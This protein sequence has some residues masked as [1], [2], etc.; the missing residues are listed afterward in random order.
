VARLRGQLQTGAD[1]QP[2]AGR[3]DPWAVRLAQ[4]FHQLFDGGIV[5]RSVDRLDAHVAVVTGVDL[6]IDRH[7]DRKDERIGRCDVDRGIADRHQVF[8]LE[9]LPVEIGHQDFGGFLLE[10]LRPVRALD[11]HPRRLA[12]AESRQ[13][14]L[15]GHLAHGALHG[16]G[17]FLFFGGNF[18]L[19]AAF[20]QPLHR[21]F[22][23]CASPYPG[24]SS[25]RREGLA[26]S[27]GTIMSRHMWR[28]SAV[29][30]PG[31]LPTGEYSRGYQGPKSGNA[32]RP[33]R[34]SPRR[35]RAT[36]GDRLSRL[37]QFGSLARP[38]PAADIQALSGAGGLHLKA[39]AVRR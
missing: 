1:L 24:G 31:G 34:S 3:V 13:R 39:R 28:L 33:S 16:F 9:G 22:H 5:D 25:K 4:G 35:P 15:I 36:N 37:V 23:A 7:D 8:L 19:H 21:Q 32:R 26:R 30:K 6:R 29:A 17:R 27:S 14:D 38:A 11:H 12:L 20:G 18:E 2:F 10:D